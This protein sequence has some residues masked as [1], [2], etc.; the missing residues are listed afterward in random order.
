MASGTA[1]S[2]PTNRLPVAIQSFSLITALMT[3]GLIVLYRFFPQDWIFAAAITFG[4]ICYHFVMRLVVGAVVTLF[5]KHINY[6]CRWFQP[7]KWEFSLYEGI[8]LK[9]WKKYLP[10]YDPSQFNLQNN[11]LEEVV[12]STCYFELVHEIIMLCSFIPLLLAIPFG[13]FPVFL[14]TSVF[15]ALFD[16]IFVITQRYNR[17]R[18]VRIMRKKVR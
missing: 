3:V 9:K 16:S 4:T 8:K 11:T 5:S 12:H 6:E 14:I 1:V 2:A 7:R 17:P 18:L 10:T 15:A 13:A